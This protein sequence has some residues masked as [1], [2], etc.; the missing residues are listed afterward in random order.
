MILP[1]MFGTSNMVM[2]T[3]ENK[4]AKQNPASAGWVD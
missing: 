4:T 1:I 2:T 3:E